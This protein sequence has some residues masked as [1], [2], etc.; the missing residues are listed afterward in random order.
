M[1]TLTC[2]DAVAFLDDYFD[3]DLS[4]VQ[5]TA[6]ESHLTDCADCITYLRSYEETV[7]LGKAAF[8]RLDEPAGD[9]LPKQL[10][11]AI[12]AARRSR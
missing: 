9:P 4:A 1:T 11:D 3:G 2:R 10:I 12:I 5:R 8:D 7:R 6:F